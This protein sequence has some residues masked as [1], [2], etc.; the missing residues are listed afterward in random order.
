MKNQLLSTRTIFI[1]AYSEKYLIKKAQYI[2]DK[3]NYELLLQVLVISSEDRLRYQKHVGMLDEQLV[4]L[5]ISH[6]TTGA[7]LLFNIAA[8]VFLLGGYS[9]SLLLAT[10]VAV[11]VCYFVIVVGI[12][13]YMSADVYGKY[14]EKSLVLQQHALENRSTDMALLEM[15]AARNNFIVT[16]LK[17]IILPVVIVTT[18]AISWP[19]AL[20]LTA[21]YVGYEYMKGHPL[22]DNKEPHLLEGDPKINLLCP[23]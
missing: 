7:T 6:K 11:V 17:N 4:Q 23:V 14:H 21:V 1:S 22:Q 8:A 18:F 10:P 3:Q 20:L 9:A 5:E 13:M 16:M 19:A 15:Q 2:S 12:A